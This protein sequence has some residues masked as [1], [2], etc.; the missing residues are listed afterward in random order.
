MDNLKLFTKPGYSDLGDGICCWPVHDIEEVANMILKN[1][2][3]MFELTRSS[4]KIVW[5]K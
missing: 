1:D 3:D 5:L 2:S 4:E